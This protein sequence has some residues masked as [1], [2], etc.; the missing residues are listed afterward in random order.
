MPRSGR[1]YRV[2]WVLVL[3]MAASALLAGCGGAED[4]LPREAVSGTV[5]LNGAPLKAGTIEFR[6]AGP[7]AANAGVAPIADGNYAIARAEGLVP[8]KYQGMITGALAEAAPASAKTEMPGDTPP[9]K[10]PVKEPIPAKY[11]AKSE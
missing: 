4:D 5:K 9:P 8:G 7:G 2:A 1:A 11:N 3:E 10:K 6:P